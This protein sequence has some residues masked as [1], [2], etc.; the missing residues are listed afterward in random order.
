MTPHLE[1][2]YHT[3]AEPYVNLARPYYNVVD[4]TVFTPTRSY[5]TKYGAPRLAQ[6]QSYSQFQWEKNVQP[7]LV[8]YQGIVKGHYDQSAGPYV[9][10]ASEAVAP[11][12]DIAR[13]SA[14]QTYHEVVLPSAMFV[15]PYA[16]QGYFLASTFTT[17]MALPSAYWVWD[18]TNAFLDGTVWPQIRVLYIDTIEPQLVRIGQRLGRHNDKT[19]SV[20]DNVPAR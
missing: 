9:N 6:A 4:R 13:T 12:Y 20:P 16:S 5:V 15:A 17:D 2:Y 14:L 19:V 7:Q 3:Y 18:K 10:K 8:K 11:Y 1:P